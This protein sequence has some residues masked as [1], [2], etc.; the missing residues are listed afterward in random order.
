MKCGNFVLLL[1]S[2]LAL[3]LTVNAVSAM[4]TV[5]LPPNKTLAIPDGVKLHLG[6]TYV[7]SVGSAIHIEKW[8]SSNWV[9]YTVDGAS[10]Q[11][12]YNGTD[13]TF[14]IIDGVNKT[15]GDGWTTV[16]GLMTVIAS[17]SVQIEWAVPSTPVTP[18]DPYHPQTSSNQLVLFKVTMNGKPVENCQIRISTSTYQEYVGTY[19]TDADG[20]ATA[21]LSVGTYD[22]S[23][24]YKEKRVSGTF[25]HIQEE[26]IELD[27]GTGQITQIPALDRTQLTRIGVGLI[28]VVGAVFAIT[29]I[30]KKRR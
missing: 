13:P 19:M 17:S 5:F 30:A 21:Y 25:Q 18:S 24:T 12:I 15:V 11:T 2:F 3:L 4:P 27:L 14:V 28:V 9:N 1:L 16:S 7:Q 26:T 8:F 29:F 23:A 10:T 20:K 6:D 22:Y